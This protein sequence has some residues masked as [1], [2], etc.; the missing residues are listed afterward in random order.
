MTTH[1]VLLVTVDGV[2]VSGVFFDRLIELSISDR[3]GVQ[4]DTLEMSFDDSPPHFASPRRGAVVRVSVRMGL[5]GAADLGAFI[6]DK[7]EN[8]CL[9]FVIRVRAHSADFRAEM[10]TQK[11][12]HW[13]GATVKDIV[14]EIAKEHD[15]EPQISDAVA[16]HKYDWIGQQD[17]S[18]LNFLER[19]AR[20]H[21]ALFTIKAGRLLW[22]ERGAGK[23]AA[24]DAIPEAVIGR[25]DVL[26]GTCRVSD[27]DVERFKTVKCYWQDKAGAKRREVVVTADKEANG[28]RVLSDPFSSEAEARRAAKAVAKEIQR[29]Q[30]R[31][32]CTVLGNPSLMAGQP[33]QYSGIRPGIDGRVFILET[34]E[35]TYSKSAGLRSSIEGRLK[36]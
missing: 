4:A 27:S 10:K 25:Q 31:T 20:R 24:G 16:G 21:D 8:E 12:R 13:D 18:D 6:V 32:S 35:L 7:V 36:V 34:V 2:P 14:T 26:I 22:L 9:P 15:L 17:E 1:P 33:M 29:G 19:L 3:E 5:R 30:I 23:T 28:E 11:S